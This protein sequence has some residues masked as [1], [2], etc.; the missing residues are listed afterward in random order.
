MNMANNNFQELLYLFRVLKDL[1]PILGR[2]GMR[3][4]YTLEPVAYSWNTG[5]KVGI[6]PTL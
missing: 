3:W 6:Y 2:L 4:K 1:D 5:C